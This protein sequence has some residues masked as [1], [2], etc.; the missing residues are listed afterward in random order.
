ML[1][2]LGL[3]VVAA[4]CGAIQIYLYVVRVAAADP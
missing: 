3:Y 1:F 2:L 4:G